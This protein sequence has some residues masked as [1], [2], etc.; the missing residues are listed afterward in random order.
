VRAV[1]RRIVVRALAPLLCASSA[2]FVAVPPDRVLEYDVKAA[3]IFNL[4][5]YTGWPSSAFDA[6][7]TPFRVCVADPDPFGRSLTQTFRN[8]AVE[9]HPVVVAVVRAKGELRGCHVLFVGQAADASGTLQQAAAAEPILTVGES[10]TFEK[11]GGII[12]FVSDAG[13]IRFDVSQQQ[14]ARAGLKLSSKVLQV[15]RRVS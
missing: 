13:R 14:A 10:A 15:A 7:S 1:F 12:T 8:E 3:Y 5:N 11:R 2:A 4:S 9:G 6:P